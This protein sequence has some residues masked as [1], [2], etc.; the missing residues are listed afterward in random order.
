MLFGMV[1]LA[2]LSTFSHSGEVAIAKPAKRF[3]EHALVGKL[4][5]KISLQH[6]SATRDAHDS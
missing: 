5:V 4:A 2:S 1:D 3:Q 6:G